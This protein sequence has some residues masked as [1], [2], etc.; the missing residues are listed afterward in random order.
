MPQ[1]LTRAERRDL[2]RAAIV[3]SA[4]KL[5]AEHGF[6]GVSLDE[7]A[8]D[9]GL[10]KG[11]VYSNFQSKEDL[12]LAVS[13]KQAFR[14][15]EDDFPSSDLPF[16]EQLRGLGRLIARASS[17]E[18]VRRVAPRELEL[19]TLALQSDRFREILVDAA[20]SQSRSLGKLIQ[21]RAKSQGVELDLS[22]DEIG[23][24]LT[25]VRLGLTRMS[26]LAPREIPQK[27]F[28]DAFE[29]IVLGASNTT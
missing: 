29:R 23:T 4:E 1:R 2:T 22:A 12:L 15:D 25:A 5:F 27:F 20:K 8:D 13:A 11:A 9:A 16:R 19:A 17:G 21:D 6:W 28:E 3:S 24:L 7:I 14:I 18:E 10:T 26:L